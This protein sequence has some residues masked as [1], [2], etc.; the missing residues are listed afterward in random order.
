MLK[1]FLSTITTHFKNTLFLLKMPILIILK[2]FET[3]YSKIE[4]SVR[5]DEKETKED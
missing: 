1:N 2:Y 4:F 3:V 5:S